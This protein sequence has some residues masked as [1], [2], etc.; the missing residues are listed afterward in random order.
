MWCD[1]NGS[2]SAENR[3]KVFY[4]FETRFA[5]DNVIFAFSYTCYECRFCRREQPCPLAN[6]T[7]GNEAN[8]KSFEYEDTIQSDIYISK[9]NVIHIL[10]KNPQHLLDHF[11]QES[12]YFHT[13]KTVLSINE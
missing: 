4:L 10:G 2:R 11:C 6:E 7:F 8:L 12:L 5:T 1:V 3:C 9:I 13:Y